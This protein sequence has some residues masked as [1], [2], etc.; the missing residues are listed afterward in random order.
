MTVTAKALINAKYAASS[1]TTE[2]TTPAL[3]KTII[4]KFTATNTDSSSRTVSVHLVPSGGAA[5]AT[6][7]VTSLLA[8]DIDESV[9]LPEL[10]N[11]ILNAGDF[12][13]VVA[14]VASKVVIRASGR[15][16]T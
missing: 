13:S 16:V 3:T 11:H 15:E 6:N 12:I 14:S 2:Y 4:D 10:K 1:L 9:E 5:D 7:R 8:I